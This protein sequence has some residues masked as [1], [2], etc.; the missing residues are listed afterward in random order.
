MDHYDN[1]ETNECV[2]I[3]FYIEDIEKWGTVFGW[4]V[5]ILFT[6][7]VIKEL[8]EQGLIKNTENR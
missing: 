6:V 7:Y 3:D 5:F 8:Y 1:M 2:N 4:G